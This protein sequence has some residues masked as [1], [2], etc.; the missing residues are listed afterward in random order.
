MSTEYETIR[1]EVDGPSAVI[2]LARPDKRNALSMQLIREVVDALDVLD[3]DN[4]V[5]GVI[6]T[7]DD[8]AFSTGMDLA[9]GREVA[10]IPDT[11]RW[12]SRARRVTTAIE[13]LSKPVV[14]AV[15]G[16]CITGGLELALAC[17]LRIAAEDA[18]LGF[19]SSKIGGSAGLG[20]TQRLPRLIGSAQAKQMLFTSD[21]IDGVRAAELGLV[22]QVVSADE[23]VPQSKRLIE[24]MAEMAPISIWLQKRAVDA[25]MS[26][27]LSSALLFEQHCTTLSFNT[28]DRAEGFSAFLE[29]RP[30]RFAGE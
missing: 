28:A 23:V 8:V 21:F 9:E 30:P 13:E 5:R 20:G 3:V 24:R 4:A 6:L 17:D 14:A 10:S 1:V 27:D 2:Q 15:R 25:G 12:L 18:T 29:K 11:F 22:N 26:M 7:G 19:T 16:Y